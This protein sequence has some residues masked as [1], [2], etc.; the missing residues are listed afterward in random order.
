MRIY[1]IL[2]FIS[3]RRWH[4]DTYLIDTVSCFLFVAYGIFM[5]VFFTSAVKRDTTIVCMCAFLFD[6]FSFAPFSPL[7]LSLSW[8]GQVVCSFTSIFCSPGIHLPTQHVLLLS[9][10][11]TEA[12]ILGS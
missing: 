7:S 4:T 11:E 9:P 8:D 2:W 12:R 1:S 10:V 3:A 6:L 5:A